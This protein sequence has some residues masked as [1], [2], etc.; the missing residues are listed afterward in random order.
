MTEQFHSL[1]LYTL[2]MI[3]QKQS[4]GSWN[5][6]PGINENILV[7][8]GIMPLVSLHTTEPSFDLGNK[9]KSRMLYPVGKSDNQNLTSWPQLWQH[10]TRELCSKVST[11]QRAKKRELYI[12]EEFRNLIIM[13]A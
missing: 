13:R 1:K 12:V 4:E 2:Q 10:M 3:V 7:P 5:Q 6:S 9:Q 8:P 11:V